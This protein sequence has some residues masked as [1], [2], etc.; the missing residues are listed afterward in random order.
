MKRELFYSILK[1]K[2][3]LILGE[4]LNAGILFFDPQS[5]HFSFEVGDLKRI[6]KAYPELN[7]NFLNQ[8][9]STLENNINR[10]GG[11]NIFQLQ[12]DKLENFIAKELFYSDAAGLSFESVERIPISENSDSSKT[13]HYLKELYL[14]GQGVLEGQRRKRNEEFILSEVN[15][16]LKRKDPSFINRIERNKTIT[17]PLIQF[18]FDFFWKSN[19][20]HLAKAIAFDLESGILIQNK[21]LQIYGA[22]EQLKPALL[23]VSRRSNVDLLVSKPI[24][25]SNFKEFDKALEIISSVKVPVNISLEKDWNRYTDNIISNA[26]ELTFL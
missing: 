16:I 6:A 22:L 7:V 17:T 5:H 15:K 19:E 24:E 3:G 8:F 4:S 9:I 13:K 21:A 2:Q 14:V 23:E 12:E 11:G 25:K 18:T 10:L 26:E 1:Y 20:N